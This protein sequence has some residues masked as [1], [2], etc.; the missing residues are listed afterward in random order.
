MQFNPQHR[1][2]K[3]LV[4]IPTGN[5]H[6]I[7]DQNLCVPRL[8]HTK[9]ES[10]F[11]WTY[12]DLPRWVMSRWANSEPFLLWRPQVPAAC[13]RGAPSAAQNAGTNCW[14]G[15]PLLSSLSP[16]I[17]QGNEISKF[18]EGIVNS[19]LWWPR[20]IFG[21]ITPAENGGDAY[22]Q[23]WTRKTWRKKCTGKNHAP[24]LSVRLSV[25]GRTPPTPLETYNFWAAQAILSNFRFG[26]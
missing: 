10:K 15:R 22:F 11:L 21:Q 5:Q 18:S 6:L 9:T 16:R 8:H 25:Q 7:W 20:E 14:A 4:Q 3:K 24:R 2:W 1:R 12:P 23:L 19:V 13:C 26:G 17:L